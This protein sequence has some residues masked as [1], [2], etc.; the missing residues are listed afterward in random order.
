MLP[1]GHAGRYRSG[2]PAL[3]AAL[4]AWLRIELAGRADRLEVW[5]RKRFKEVGDRL[6]GVNSEIEDELKSVNTQVGE[7]R[8]RMARLEGAIDGVVA[9]TRDAAPAK[10]APVRTSERRR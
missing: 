3:V 9:G 1:C 10:R 6:N 5:N 7:L 8:E 4:S 2:H